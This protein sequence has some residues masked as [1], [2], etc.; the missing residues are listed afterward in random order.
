LKINKLKIKPKKAFTLIEILIVIALIGIVSAMVLGSYRTSKDQKAVETEARKLAASIREAQNNSLTGKNGS[1]CS[2]SYSAQMIRYG[3]S[4]NN[5][6]DFF[7]CNSATYYLSNG[8]TFFDNGQPGYGHDQGTIGFKIP[9]GTILDSTG[10][11]LA[12]WLLGPPTN[13][14]TNG[15][16][17]IV[18]KR[19]LESY[20]VCLYLSG[21]IEENKNGCPI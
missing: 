8:V 6:Y 19:N 12:G 18:L 13:H 9:F 1:A 11:S 14:S 3:T 4:A 20:H 2:T 21:R 17:D 5:R 10:S 15:A 16:L 7:D